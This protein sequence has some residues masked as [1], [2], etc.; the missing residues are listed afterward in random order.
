[1]LCVNCHQVNTLDSLVIK[2]EN[3]DLCCMVCQH[4]SETLNAASVSVQL[5]AAIRAHIRKYGQSWS[6]CDENSCE[7][8]S[9]QKS[10]YAHCPSRSCNGTLNLE[11]SAGALYTQ[12]QFYQHLFNVE[13]FTK[14]MKDVA[15]KESTQLLTLVHRPSLASL[16][17]LVQNYM[18]QSLHG[19]VD[20]KQLFSFQKMVK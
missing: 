11:Y 12:L 17:Q 16:L 13:R 14:N 3:G 10:V 6:V 5:N 18:D 4:C 8:R 9:R 2:S 20:M 7:L 1:M 15:A 19:V